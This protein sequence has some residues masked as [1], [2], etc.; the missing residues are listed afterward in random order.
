MGSSSSI[1][2]RVARAAEVALQEQ[3]HVSTVEVLV[4]MGWLQPV[5]RDRWR[6][7]RVPY[8]E[9]VV[10]AGSGKVST[11][12]LAL[13]RWAREEG[14]QPS[15]AAYVART[16]DHRSLQFTAGGDPSTE[17]AYRTHWISPALSEAERARLVERSSR[18]P[19]LV[20]V[21][22]LADWTCA[23][24]GGT[25]DL[26][27]MEDDAPLCLVCADLDHLSYLP[28]GDAT[29]TRR[30][31]KV[32]R[33]AAVVVRFSRSRRRYERQGI[34]VEEEALLAAEAS[35]SADA[36]ARNRR[37]ARDAERRRDADVQ[38]VERL[39]AEIG[40]LFPGCPPE[41]GA[42]I[43]AHT[44]ARGSGRIGRTAAGQRLDEHAV[45]LAVVASV[46]HRDTDY[47]ALLMAGVPREE[48]RARVRGDVDVVLDNWRSGRR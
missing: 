48:A 24:C 21:S 13:Q 41:R 5:H 10:Q 46:R 47:D 20:V 4:G 6:Q 27:L 19:D 44:A 26:L 15:E 30:A 7:G 34:L 2:Q 14:L 3:G 17:V 42:A 32:S 18:A 28:A 8:L 37:R 23:R 1:E 33:L 16:H 22:P 25:G 11:V 9:L 43:A 38:L 12:M 36:E 29:L 31:K 45:E 35:S 39:T 40:R